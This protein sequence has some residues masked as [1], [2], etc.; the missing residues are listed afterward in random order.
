M[1]RPSEDVTESRLPTE[2][3]A[4][5]VVV[6]GRLADSS[7]ATF[8]V[9]VAGVRA[10]H[11]PIAGERPLWDFP[12]GTL[13]A[14]EHG[15]WLIADALAEHDPGWAVVPHTV[16]GEGPY[17]PGSFQLWIEDQGDPVVDLVPTSRVASLGSGWISVLT[18]E[19]EEGA[20]VSVV[21]A[22]RGD[23]R[24]L[25]LLDVVLNNSD[26]KGGH[27]LVDAARPE[28]LVQ[29]IDHGLAFHVDPKLRTVLWGWIGAPLLAAE[30]HALTALAA[31]LESDAPGSLGRRLAALL[32]SEER[33]ATVARTRALVESGTFPGPDPRWPS[34]PWPAF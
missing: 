29:G 5:D 8:L 21:H 11:K 31:E 10:I 14:R 15:A 33:D 27:V 2:F 13:A 19:D 16:L 4:D 24:R 18:G 1:N 30:I 32:S 20:E 3:T 22:D 28:P 6:L 9:E 12:D 34:V 7:N 23:L 26:R 25:A 17:G